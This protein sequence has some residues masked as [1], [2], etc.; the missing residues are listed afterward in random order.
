MVDLE[1]LKKYSKDIIKTGQAYITALNAMNEY[2]EN[3]G[4][5]PDVV[6]AKMDKDPEFDVQKE[7]GQIFATLEAKL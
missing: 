6:L 5:E 7:L 4:E 2:G 1:K 3:C